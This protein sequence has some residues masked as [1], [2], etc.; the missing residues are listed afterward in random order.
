MTEG[1]SNYNYKRYLCKRVF[2]EEEEKDSFK[3]KW[4]DYTAA[5][6]ELSPS[7]MKLFMYLAKNQDGY[8]FWFSSKDYCQTFNVSDKTYRNAR[9]ELIDKGYLKEGEKNHVYFNASGAFKETYETL[10]ERAIELGQQ[11]QLLDTKRYNEFTQYLE[12][13]DIVNTTNETIKKVKVKEAIALAED[14]L[15]DISS[16]KLSQLF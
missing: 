5:A 6:N 13:L 2:H 9:N 12:E 7:A 15:N 11:I 14:I 3:I 4:S 16:T 1:G 10:K 8:E